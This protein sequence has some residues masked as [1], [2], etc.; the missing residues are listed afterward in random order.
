[1]RPV[2]NGDRWDCN[3]AL[4]R[5]GTCDA[6]PTPEGGCR[7]V[8]QCRPRRSLRSIRVRFV[9]A[10]AL[11]VLGLTLIVLSADSR[12]LMIAPGPLARPHAQLIERS[13]AN[14]KCAACHAAAEG[15]LT[16]AAASF[17]LGSSTQ[18]AQ[19]Q[20]CM[21]CHEKTISP[22]LALSPHNVSPDILH[23]A[24][25]R[26]GAPAASSVACAACHREHHGTAADLTAIDNAACQTCHKRRFES[27]AADH[28]DF[29]AWPNERRTRIAFNHAAHRDKHFAERK[30]TFDCRSCHVEDA[31]GRAQVLAPYRSACARCHDEKMKTSLASGASMLS[32]PVIDV[33][34][35]K[36]TGLDV[37]AWP[38]AAIGD[39]DGQ[40]PPAMK[41]LLAGD[42][43]AS[44][45][46]T[47]L[48]ATFD[49][50]DVNPKDP[51]HLKASAALAIAIKK[52]LH[53]FEANPETT[54][55]DRLRLALGREI[56]E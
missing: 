19:S 45:A 24:A 26:G 36:S 42:E 31:T 11:F 29:G 33:D 4:L 15:S 16:V 27:F 12:N 37:G 23:D 32:L 53:D 1:M 44:L 13:G 6:G 52:L 54:I 25:E 47:A 7:C 2:R 18:P 38:K 43:K 55:R 20:L 50:Q 9:T 41:L 51:Q 30:E 40:L 48:G 10:G 49:F 21:K 8:P 34:A 28:P 56:S 17:M 35:L 5:G 14:V 46:M 39:F 22:E 3:R